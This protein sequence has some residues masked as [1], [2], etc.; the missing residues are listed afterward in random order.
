MTGFFY[1][2]ECS[3]FNVTGMIGF[4]RKEEILWDVVQIIAPGNA[5]IHGGHALR[6]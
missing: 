3:I 1:R 2:S 6:I 5:C 4:G